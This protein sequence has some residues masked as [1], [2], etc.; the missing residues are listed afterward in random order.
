MGLD[1]EKVRR[2]GPLSSNS[3]IRVLALKMEYICEKL[4]MERY[5]KSYMDHSMS[6]KKASNLVTGHGT[7]SAKDSGL[8][9]V[10]CSKRRCKPITAAAQ[11]TRAKVPS[12]N[13]PGT[14]PAFHFPVFDFPHCPSMQ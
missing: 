12:L 13:G 9:W 6:L 2:R 8:G 1:G 14:S 4:D 7:F 3:M 11:A 5:L 10:G